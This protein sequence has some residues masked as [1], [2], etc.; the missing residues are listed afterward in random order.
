MGDDAQLDAEGGISVLRSW[1][2][3]IGGGSLRELPRIALGLLLEQY[4]CGRRAG[5][6]KL[7]VLTQG[8]EREL[9]RRFNPR[10]SAPWT[11]SDGQCRRL[12]WLPISDARV[13]RG[14]IGAS[15]VSVRKIR[16]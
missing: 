5:G 4:Q 1:R 9:A 14:Y 10:N 11:G 2:L 3:P 7:Q 6:L 12:H 13:T 8:L 15:E 16:T